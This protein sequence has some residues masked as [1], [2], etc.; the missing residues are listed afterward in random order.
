MTKLYKTTLVAVLAAL[1][2]GAA[3]F[4][5]AA[6]I[7]IPTA[8]KSTEQLH[9]EIVKAASDAC[10]SDLRGEP[11]ATYMYPQC[12]RS[13]IKR[14]VAQVGDSKL[15]AYDKASPTAVRYAAR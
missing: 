14:A 15:A 10:W 1:A 9:A 3:S 7:R 4:A 13:S 6:E 8:G 2:A 11:M 12:V 5:G